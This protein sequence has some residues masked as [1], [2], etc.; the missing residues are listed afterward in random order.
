VLLLTPLPGTRLWEKMESE[1]R[2][3]AD[4]FPED[5]R[6]YTLKYPVARY[7][8]LSWGDLLRER[9]V[10]SRAFYSYPRII[11]RVFSTLWRTRKPIITLVSLVINLSCRSNYKNLCLEH[12]SYRG[13]DL[14][15]GEAQA[16]QAV[17]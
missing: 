3:I 16:K 14:S 1:G 17:L 10:C 9:E 2:I 6:Y 13:L 8:H 15:R 4:A 11:R 12:D 7:K 5:W